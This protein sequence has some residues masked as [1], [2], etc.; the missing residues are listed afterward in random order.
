MLTSEQLRRAA[1]LQAT[2]EQYQSELDA[3]YN[4]TEVNGGPGRFSTIPSPRLLGRP[5]GR[6]R[7]LATP[8]KTGVSRKFSPAAIE[9]IRQAQRAR[10]RRI[11]K[12]G[13]ETA[14]NV[15]APV[16]APAAEVAPVV[17]APVAAAPAE[18]VAAPASAAPVNNK[19]KGKSNKTAPAAETKSEGVKAESALAAA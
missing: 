19:K 4:E 16:T 13:K 14:A 2:I 17:T 9:A 18:T 15:A 7:K 12:A 3:I 1:E 5:R 10:W 8:T 11:K 6:P